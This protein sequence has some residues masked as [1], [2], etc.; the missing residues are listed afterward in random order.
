LRKGSTRPTAKSPSKRQGKKVN[1]PPSL[2]RGPSVWIDLSTEPDQPAGQVTLVDKTLRGQPKR[3]TTTTQYRTCSQEDREDEV[4]TELKRRPMRLMFKITRGSNH[5]GL[6]PTK[7]APT[8]GRH[9]EWSLPPRRCRPARWCHPTGLLLWPRWGPILEKGVYVHRREDGV[10]V[11]LEIQG[12]KLA[13]L[14]LGPRREPYGD[15]TNPLVLGTEVGKSEP[16][17]HPLVHP[18]ATAA[19]TRLGSARR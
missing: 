11:R 13:P 12:V 15:A 8:K 17:R 19:Q 9:W 16:L 7:G 5:K 6:A 3:H 10:G 4:Q 18:A 1:R 14:W 2:Y